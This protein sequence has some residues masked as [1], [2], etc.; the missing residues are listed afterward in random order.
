M[1][2]QTDPKMPRDSTEALLGRVARLEAEVLVL[3]T[4]QVV[5]VT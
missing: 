2:L 5:T 1:Q 4:A 3:R